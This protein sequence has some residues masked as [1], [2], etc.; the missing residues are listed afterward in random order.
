M[1]KKNMKFDNV[2][3]LNINNFLIIFFILLYYVFNIKLVEYYKM[4][5]EMYT[6]KFYVFLWYNVNF[7]RV[8]KKF[9]IRKLKI[10]EYV[11]VYIRLKK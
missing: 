4:E 10:F 5:C 2:I 8:Y 9:F 1:D 6:K 3:F 11:F 7:K